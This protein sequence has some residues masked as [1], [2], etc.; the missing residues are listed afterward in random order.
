MVLIK[1]DELSPSNFSK[2]LVEFPQTRLQALFT[3]V[4]TDTPL[5]LV[6]I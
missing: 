3:M 6:N 5:V 4:G 2:Q 1:Q